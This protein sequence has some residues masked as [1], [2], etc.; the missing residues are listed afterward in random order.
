RSSHAVAPRYTQPQ[1]YTCTCQSSAPNTHIASGPPN[2]SNNPTPTFAF[3][4]DQSPVTFQCQLDGGAWSSCTSPDTL[5]TLAAG[6]HTFSVRAKNGAGTT[7]PSPATSTWTIDLTSPTVPI[8]APTPYLN[9]SDP[10]HHT[11]TATTPDS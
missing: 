4:S 2:P 9:A 5:G 8:T 6:S 10:T 1:C 3:S 7:D 11:V